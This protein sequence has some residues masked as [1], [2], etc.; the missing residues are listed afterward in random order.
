[1]TT[2]EKSLFWVCSLLLLLVFLVMVHSILLPFV[3]AAIIAYFLNP[4][5]DKLQKM[6]CSRNYATIVIVGLFFVV[7]T[8][9]IILVAP[10]LYEQVVQFSEKVPN[11]ANSI[12]TQL[13]PSVT[14]TVGRIN[15]NLMERIQEMLGNISG[16]LFELVGQFLTQIMKS[17]L[18]FLNIVSLIFITPIVSFYILRDWGNIVSKIDSWLP[19]RNAE[20][21]REQMRKIDLTLSGYIRGQLNVCLLMGAFYGIGLS[22]TGLDFGL[23]I[24]FA[25]GILTFIPYAGFFLG[26]VIGIAVAFFQFGLSITLL[27]VLIVFMAGQVIESNFITPKLVGDKVGLHPVWLIFGMLAGGALFGFIGVLIAVPA[28]AIIGVLTRFCLDQYLHST[29][30]LSSPT[31]DND[32]DYPPFSQ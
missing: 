18:A 30:Y 1:M 23:F 4:A 7:S 12:R 2:K 25:T 31:L 3:V 5:A 15:A 9:V 11:Y 21:I 16:I 6:G 17:G 26:F 20:Q 19:Q 29:L 13:I 32:K 10:L 22:A 8:S 14:K 24:G 27:I 28:T